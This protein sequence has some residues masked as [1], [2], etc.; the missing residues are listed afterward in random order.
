MP[1]TRRPPSPPSLTVRP[2][3]DVCDHNEINP[4]VGGATGTT[5]SRRHSIATA[6]TTSSTSFRITWESGPVETYGGMT[7]SRTEP[8]LRQR[9]SSTSTGARRRPRRQPS[10]FCRSLAINTV[11]SSSEANCGS[12]SMA[13]CWCCGIFDQALPLN[14]RHSGRVYSAAADRLRASLGESP[15]LNEF[16]S[17]IASLQNLPP[18]TTT[19]PDKIAERQRE[20][21]AGRG[22]NDSSPNSR[23]C[24]QPSR[25]RS[26]R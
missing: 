9:C 14:P 1:A 24:G 8:V 12:S 22:S 10:C 16:F 13:A 21:G 20:I 15:A 5:S 17:I 11:A 7:C 18:E 26:R 23:P 3:Y 19:D 6:C 25:R 2:G 4:E